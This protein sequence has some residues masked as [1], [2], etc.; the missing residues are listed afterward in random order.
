MAYWWLWTF[1]WGKCTAEVIPHDFWTLCWNWATICNITVTD[2]PVS[3]MYSC[4]I[5]RN[6][7]CCVGQDS[8]PAH[9]AL[10]TI[11]LLQR[12]TPQF[13]LLDFW[14]SNSPYLTPVDC[15]I[16][17]MVQDRVYQIPVWDV[18]VLR[19]CL[20]NT[21]HSLSQSIM[22]DGVYEWWKRF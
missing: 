17:G 20:I 2:L 21:W 13:I 6:I 3:P 8:A 18:I 4:Y 19:H 1:W 11:E 15:R 9:H 12:K 7:N 5:I 22:Y 16:W 14:P 10:Q